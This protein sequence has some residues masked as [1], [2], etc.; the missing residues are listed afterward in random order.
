MDSCFL[1]S[2]ATCGVAVAVGI[3]RGQRVLDLLERQVRRP[4]VVAP[5]RHAVRLVDDEEA[6][7]LPAQLLRQLSGRGALGRDVDDLV[8][9]LFDALEGLALFLARLR[10]VEARRDGAGAPELDQLIAHERQQRRDDDG[11]PRQLER[12]QLIRERLARARRHDG[13]HVL[14]A[15]Q[16]ADHALLPGTE[17]AQVELA[18]QAALQGI[19]LLLLSVGA[20]DELGSTTAAATAATATAFTLGPG[21]LAR[22]R[23]LLRV[24]RRVRLRRARREMR[25]S[26]R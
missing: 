20:D 3:G 1:M 8:T 26:R 4:E 16:I 22:P 23:V 19:E 17:L 13:Q 18:A 10:R 14:A 25:L 7:L 5:L 24:R 6:H 11:D 2:S 12:R 15:E 9:A 21:R